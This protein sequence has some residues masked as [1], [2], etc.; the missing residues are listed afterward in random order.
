MFNNL[1]ANEVCKIQYLCHK[2]PGLSHNRFLKSHV[3]WH[4]TMLCWNSGV[5]KLRFIGSICLYRK[6]LS[7]ISSS[8]K[9]HGNAI[10]LWI[11]AF[12]S[13]GWNLSKQ[14]GKCNSCSRFSIWW[15]VVWVTFTSLEGFCGFFGITDCGWQSNSPPKDALVLIP[16]TCNYVRRWTWKSLSHVWLFATPKYSPGQNTG[17][18]SLSPSPG[19]LPNPGVEPKVS[20]ITGRFF[21]QLSH[22]EAQEYWSG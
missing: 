8:G 19:D 16:G 17:V 22:R 12:E 13:S 15:D 21:Y 1:T 6:G 14:I 20:C 10:F 9:E 2:P 18:G 5:A 11:L 3:S 7:R 4:W